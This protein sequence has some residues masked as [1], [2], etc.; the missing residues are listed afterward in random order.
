MRGLAVVLACVFLFGFIGDPF[1]H[2]QLP[3]VLFSVMAGVV[4]AESGTMWWSDLRPR[5]DTVPEAEG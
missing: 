5:P 4:T 2:K 3:L 1:F